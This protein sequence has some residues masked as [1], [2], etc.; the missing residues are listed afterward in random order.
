MMFDE[1]FLYMQGEGKLLFLNRLLPILQERC[2]DLETV[3][4]VAHDAEITNSAKDA[5][6]SVWTVSRDEA[7]SSIKMEDR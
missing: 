1:P 3:I 4:I 7:G 5:F 2:T 6:D